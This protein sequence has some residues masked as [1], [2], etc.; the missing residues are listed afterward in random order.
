MRQDL[1]RHRGAR[2]ARA[3]RPEWDKCLAYLREGDVLVITRLS[4]AMRSVHHMLDLVNGTR[5]SD[6]QDG[7]SG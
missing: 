4:R 2:Q 3:S 1:H 5:A 6:Y 7:L